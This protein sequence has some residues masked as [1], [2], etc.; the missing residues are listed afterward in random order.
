M[1]VKTRRSQ[2]IRDEVRKWLNQFDWDTEIT[3]TFSNDI[4]EHQARQTLKRFWNRVDKCLYGNAV[5]NFNKRCERMNL[6]EGQRNVSRFHF[7]ILARLPTDRF[8]TVTE[9]C[10]YLR[11][12]WRVENSNNYIVSFH[13]IKNRD[14][15]T[16][17]ST[18][19]IGRNDCD[20][21]VIDSSHISAAS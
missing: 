14:R 21:L 7:H 17:Y 6:L 13:P 11:E 4:S 20:T 16:N 9:F 12:Q 1:N 19:S 15:Y 8:S 2:N 3:L 18:K 5:R 10:D